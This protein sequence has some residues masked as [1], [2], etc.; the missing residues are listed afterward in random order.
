MVIKKRKQGWIRIVEAFVAILLVMGIL[1]IIVGDDFM[2]RKDGSEEIY[3]IQLA[4]LRDVQV[5]ETLRNLI[6]G[7]G[8]PHVK[9]GDESFPSAVED[10]INSRILSYL[11]CEAH[12]CDFSADMECAASDLPLDKSIYVRSVMITATSTQY[13]PKQLKLF[14]WEK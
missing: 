7:V 10:K 11:G 2:Q 8:E 5:E 13:N 12:I 4:I 9:T 3:A 1:L 14:C 6:L